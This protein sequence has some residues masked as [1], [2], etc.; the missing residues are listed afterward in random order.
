MGGTGN[1]SPTSMAIDPFG[2]L[3]VTG[4]FEET[5]DFNP[6]NTTTNLIS[7]GLTDLFLIK[8]NFSGGLLFAK[9]I[10]GTG[11]D[12]ST[13]IKIDPFSNLF[14][15]GYFSETTDLTLATMELQISFL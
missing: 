7:N 11:N 10:G 3:F 1:D 13:D 4:T 2:F 9:S 15:T 8:L 12:G 6:G 14:I 5:V